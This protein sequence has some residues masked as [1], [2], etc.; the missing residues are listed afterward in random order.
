MGIQGKDEAR[1]DRN[2][3]AGGSEVAHE[4]VDEGLLSNQVLDAFDLA[5]LF[6]GVN[7]ARL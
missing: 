3:E 5:N 4:V 1:G 7:W 6:V 2:E